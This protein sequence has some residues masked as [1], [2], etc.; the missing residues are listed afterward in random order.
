MVGSWG[1]GIKL[2]SFRP[3]N[4][5][6]HVTFSIVHYFL[7][8]VLTLK[9]AVLPSQGFVCLFYFNTL[10]DCNLKIYEI[11]VTKF[12]LVFDSGVLV[13]KCRGQVHWLWDQHLK[14]QMTRLHIRLLTDLCRD[15]DFYQGTMRERMTHSTRLPH[16][17]GFC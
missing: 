1:I 5:E 13:E 15:T 6:K 11:F 4:F 2:L 16:T 12:R 14:K 7:S 10:V 8:V 9:K 3:G 17:K